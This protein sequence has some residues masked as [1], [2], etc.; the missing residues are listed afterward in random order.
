MDPK[1][2]APKVLL[3]SEM[4]SPLLVLFSHTQEKRNSNQP[5][6]SRVKSVQCIK[7]GM[8]AKSKK[9]CCFRLYYSVLV[10]FVTKCESHIFSFHGPHLVLGV[11]KNEGFIRLIGPL[12]RVPRGNEGGG[13]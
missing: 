6:R 7:V 11:R 1:Q 5:G 9:W 8:K 13:L 10:V 3:P 2:G 12:S 4:M